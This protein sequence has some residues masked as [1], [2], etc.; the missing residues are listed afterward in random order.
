M[1]VFS[2]NPLIHKAVNTAHCITGP[3]GD[4]FSVYIEKRKP[5]G[6]KDQAE[7]RS[8]SRNIASQ[9]PSNGKQVTGEDHRALNSPHAPAGNAGR[10]A[11]RA[12]AQRRAVI[13]APSCPLENRRGPSRLPATLDKGT[14][15][16]SLAGQTCKDFFFLCRAH[17]KRT[18]LRDARWRPRWW[19]GPRQPSAS[20]QMAC[21][22]HSRDRQRSFVVLPGKTET[23]VPHRPQ[24]DPGAPPQ[25]SVLES[26]LLDGSRKNQ[27][28]PHP[29]SESVDSKP[30]VQ[31]RKN[32][33]R[34][35]KQSRW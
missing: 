19:H 24:A 33:L 14:L 15:D 21:T 30:D 27:N 32:I 8:T 12:G 23:A 11:A 1:L 4:R 7:K 29:A 16:T 26:F 17:V 34:M 28:Y 31:P 6:K 20:A 9:L 2:H 35:L 3:Q 18:P 13:T 5:S 10:T 25:A 22:A